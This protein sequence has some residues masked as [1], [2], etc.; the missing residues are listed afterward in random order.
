M[1]LRAL[2]NINSGQY[3][4]GDEF[5]MADD[6]AFSLIKAKAAEKIDQDIIVDQPAPIVE[7]VSEQTVA[8][9][10]E[11]TPT[12]DPDPQELQAAFEATGAVVTS[13]QPIEQSQPVPINIQLN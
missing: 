10:A 13:E 3:V 5:E 6:E 9:L 11:E 1:R 2:S 4:K 7:E 8:P 12:Q